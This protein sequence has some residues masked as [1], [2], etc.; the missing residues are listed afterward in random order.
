MMQYNGSFRQKLCSR[1]QV[2]GERNTTLLVA[3][4][5]PRL[6]TQNVKKWR[7]LDISKEQHANI[8]MLSNH[9]ERGERYESE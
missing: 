6:P 5:R 7:H 1:S 9:D 3:I 8:A 4:L 2:R